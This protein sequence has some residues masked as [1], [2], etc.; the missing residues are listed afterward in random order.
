MSEENKYLPEVQTRA[1]FPIYSHKEMDEKNDDDHID[2]YRQLPRKGVFKD[3]SYS[4]KV[5]NNKEQVPKGDNSFKQLKTDPNC[6]DRFV[7]VTVTSLQD[8]SDI[9]V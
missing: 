9:D 7:F 8:Q 1:I 6:K 2:Y 5:F 4:F 3:E